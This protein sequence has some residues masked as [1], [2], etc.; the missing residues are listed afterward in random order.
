[1]TK[2]E[3]YNVPDDLHDIITLL[4]GFDPYREAG[5]CYFDEQAARK[6]IDFF[7]SCLRL[8]KGVPG[9]PPFHLEKWQQSIVANIFGWKTP[10][11]VRRFRKAWIYIPKKNGKTAFAAGLLLYML[12]CDREPGAEIYGAAASK[13]QAALV[14]QHA[15]GMVAAEPAL[16]NMLTVYGAKGGGVIKSICRNDDPTSTYRVISADADTGDG[17]NPHFAIIDETHR[18]A[19]REFA[20][21]V[22][23]STAARMQSLVV[24]ITT[25]DFNR[26]SLCNEML[27]YARQVRDGIVSDPKLLPAIYEASKDDDWEDPE[28]WRKV[29][30]NLGVTITEEMLADLCDKAKHQPSFLNTFLRL[31]LNIVT[32]SFEAWIADHAWRA[33]AIVKPEKTPQEIRKEQIEKLKGR[34]CYIGLDLGSSI[35]LT[36]C[37]ALFPKTIPYSQE[38]G[39][40]QHAEYDTLLD[41]WIPKDNAEV[42]AKVDKVNYPQWHREGWLHYTAGAQTDY[43]GVR[44]HINWMFDYFDVQ[45]IGYDPWVAKMLA[46]QLVED[47]GLPMVM[48]RQGFHTLSEP[49]KHFESSVMSGWIHHTGNPILT[50]NVA[51]CAILKDTNDNIRPDKKKSTERIDGVVAIVIAMTLAML[52]EEKPVSPYEGGVLVL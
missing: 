22:E 19:K 6:A 23:S 49:S 24:H 1:M 16:S 43:E 52:R 21:M 38:T 26:A 12:V 45:Q 36:A 11:G 30:P 28:T 17:I 47:D 29:N 7:P 44:K 34:K 50:W 51:N 5:D 18:L 32:E 42:R 25:A 46:Q 48:V 8:V 20:D 33:C 4:P 37:A 3:Q 13:D 15:A 35:D 39:V 2:A 10:K 14:F 40:Q 9:K 31:H 41:F 27:T